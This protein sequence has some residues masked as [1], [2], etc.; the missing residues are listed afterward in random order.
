MKSSVVYVVG[1]LLPLMRSSLILSSHEV[2]LRNV[3]NDLILMYSCYKQMVNTRRSSSHGDRRDST[4][5][6][7]PPPITKF[8]TVEQALMTQTQ[9]L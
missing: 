4:N 2:A 9:L 7:N 5:S 1:F 6:S 8:S 3:K